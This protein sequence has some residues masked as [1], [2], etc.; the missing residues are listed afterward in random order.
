MERCN[1]I[2]YERRTIMDTRNE[3]FTNMDISVQ[4]TDYTITGIELV[5]EN[6]E[7]HAD[8]QI[9]VDKMK[10]FIEGEN[11]IFH[12]N[13]K[14]KITEKNDTDA[15]MAWIDSG[16]CTPEGK[17]I[18]ISLLKKWDD[19]YSGF[20]V[21]PAYFLK[22]GMCD[23]L[24]DKYTEKAIEKN[25]KKF[26]DEYYPEH[27]QQ[28][29]VPHMEVEKRVEERK[30]LHSTISSVNSFPQKLSNVT[31]QI[32]DSL[33]F[34]NWNSI[35]GLDR[36]I[37]IMGRRIGQLV[38]KNKEQYY[39]INN[40]KSVIVNSGLLNTWGK[41]YLILYK[42]NETYKTYIAEKVIESKQD[43]LD[44]D[45][46]REQTYKDLQP[47]SFFEDDE[48]KFIPTIED[49]DIDLKSLAHIV[50]ERK[51][52]FPASLQ[53]ESDNKIVETIK[54]TLE[55][56]LQMQ[57]RDNSYAKAHYSGKT[58]RISWLLP[59]HI[60]A[61]LTEEPELV[62]LID[63]TENFY[64]IKTVLIFDDDLKDKIT[65]LSLYRKYW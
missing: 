7:K 22:K 48:K 15:K 60:D 43:Y 61:K 19:Y 35:S 36:Y 29:T 52:R 55:R 49:F 17:P 13:E 8:A 32:F 1:T 33:L 11:A 16:Y 24:N 51:D 23:K 53:Q 4:G 20:F 27:L 10:Q 3:D 12:F 21:G 34:E 37:K 14:L 9:N 28:R 39:V 47:I 65:S 5:K 63:R 25:Y 44:N 40:L 31:N 57:A 64:K 6:I 2:E 30:P 62:M 42:Y 26:N 58:G 46:S 38:E 41:D 54:S 18:F 45:F 50:H 59:W 56:G